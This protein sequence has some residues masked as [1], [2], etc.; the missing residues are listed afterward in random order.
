MRRSSGDGTHGEGTRAERADSAPG[1]SA[2]RQ[3]RPPRAARAAPAIARPRFDEVRWGRIALVAGIVAAAVPLAAALLLPPEVARRGARAFVAAEDRELRA[4]LH[5]L[6]ATWHPGTRERLLATARADGAA[7]RLAAP[8]ARLLR[9]AD[10]AV[11]DALIEVA[12]EYA[13]ALG[14]PELRP[15]VAALVDAPRPAVAARAVA[16]ADRLE[17]WSRDRVTEL[18]TAGAPAVRAAAL[19][20]VAA[21]SDEPWPEIAALLDDADAGVRAAAIDAVP[22]NPPAAVVD[23]LR[24][25]LLLG[26]E[27]RTIAALLAIGR[28]AVIGEFEVAVAERLRSTEPE[29]Q[30]AMLDV[31]ASRGTRLAQPERV[32]ALCRDGTI[33]PR[34]RARAMYC[35]EQTGSADPAR[36]RAELAELDPLTR[37]CAARCLLAAGEHDGSTLL[38]DLVDSDDLEA[39]AASRRLLA[40]LTGTSPT[41]SSARFR[42]VLAQTGARRGGNLPPPGIEFVAGLAPGAPGR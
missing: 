13:G 16:A 27:A 35:L 10:A 37:H 3:A 31:L 5:E 21:R 14:A 6:R 42:Q 7:A 2:A 12:V 9:G 17:P 19:R 39:A 24:S 36:I 30:L 38:L 1:A 18:L 15:L 34:V 22:P 4:I 25:M 41:A 11:D 28:T 40:R 8:L 29:V 20:L 33:E 32:W 26:D 23:A